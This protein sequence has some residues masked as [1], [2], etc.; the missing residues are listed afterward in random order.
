MVAILA[1]V[2]QICATDHICNCYVVSFR[3]PGCA[4]NVG[5]DCFAE[6][7]SCAGVDGCGCVPSFPH[8]HVATEG[9]PSV[10]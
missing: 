3:P 10:V 4:V 6:G 7:Q 8:P 2:L 9:V 5:G 1:R